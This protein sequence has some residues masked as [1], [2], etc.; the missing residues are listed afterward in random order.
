VKRV[1]AAI[2]FSTSLASVVHA[3]DDALARARFLDQ[4]GA[5]AYA[6]GRFRDAAALF[7][8]SFR[9]G[10]PA[11]E[12][13]NV[14]RCQLKLDDPDA[15][16]RTLQA[17][18]DRTDLGAEDRAEGQRLEGDIAKRIST[19]VVAS[20]PSGAAVSVDGHVVGATPWT[21]TLQPGAH[22][23]LIGPVTKHIVAKDGRAVILSVELDAPEKPEEEPHEK[24]PAHNKPKKHVR[25]FFGELGVIGSVSSLGGGAVVTG[26]ASPE[27]A[28]GFAP[29]VFRD[30]T[31]G[32]GLRFRATYDQWSTTGT[33]SNAATSCVP[34]N[35]YNAVEMLVVPTVYASFRVSDRVRLGGRVGF[36]GAIYASGSPIAGDLFAPECLWGGS[37]APDGYA[38]FDISISL[39]EQLRLV[40]Y[41]IT[42]D[43]HPAY[44]GAR[45]DASI[46]ASGPWVRF[47]AGLSLAVDL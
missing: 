9:A 30:F 41:P 21:S 26:A 44:V 1:A 40:V 10:G 25:R 2:L 43:I 45:S 47:G 36:G 28:F 46:D 16:R 22:E 18:L 42:F 13:W 39:L 15:A 20:T 4:Q 37:L 11:T 33:V 32:I 27:V 8:E 17:Y 12:L 34:P 31:V 19:F 5:R 24:R 14:A 3:Q 23:I 35:D 29:F 7:N 38:A 6:E